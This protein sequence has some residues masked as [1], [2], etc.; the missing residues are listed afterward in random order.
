MHILHVCSLCIPIYYMSCPCIHCCL[1]AK[2]IFAE[3]KKHTFALYVFIILSYY[4]NFNIEIF[5][6]CCLMLHNFFFFV[7]YFCKIS[8]CLSS[9]RLVISPVNSPTFIVERYTL[10]S[11]YFILPLFEM[12]PRLPLSL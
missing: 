8:L 2:N 4:G 11:L 1:R 9:A 7:E 12:S 3:K 6:F 5:L 10:S